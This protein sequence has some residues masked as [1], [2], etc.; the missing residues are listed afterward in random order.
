MNRT[1]D[2]AEAELVSV[3]TSAMPASTTVTPY[4]NGGGFYVRC[5]WKLHDDPTRPNKPSKNILVAF[6][7]VFPHDYANLSTAETKIVWDRIDNIV[8]TRLQQFDP[9]NNRPVSDPPTEEW[10][11]PMNVLYL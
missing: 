9:S 10:R 4:Y 5:R 3:V 6:D 7:E 2:Q 8:Q 11:I 1:K